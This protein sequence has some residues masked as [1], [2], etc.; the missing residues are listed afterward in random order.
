MDLNRIDPNLLVAIIGIAVAIVGIVVTGISTVSA[1]R[2]KVRVTARAA[3]VGGR[4]VYRLDVINA[5]SG[6]VQIKEIRI[7]MPRRH[8]DFNYPG[9]VHKHAM[10]GP[11]LLHTLAGV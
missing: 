8:Y 2:S 4:T 1:E 10:R 9:P 5:G 6:N 7:L 11:A 3:V